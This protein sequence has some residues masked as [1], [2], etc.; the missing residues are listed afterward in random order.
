MNTSFIRVA[1]ACGSV[2]SGLLARG[3]RAVVAARVVAAVVVVVV[4]AQVDVVEYDA[5]DL[6]A[7]VLKEL[8]RASDDA[9]RSLA[10][11]DDEQHAVYERRG[12]H[13]VRERADGRRVDDDVRERAFER[14]YEV[15]H[16]LRADQLGRVRRNRAG[17]QNVQ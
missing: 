9:A 12:E 7:N 4:L 2:R 11:V 6:R 14:T 8:L 10:A 15:A 3:L 13:A 17:G 1:S 5:E 16:L